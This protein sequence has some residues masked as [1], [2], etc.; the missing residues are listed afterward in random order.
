MKMENIEE[1]QVRKLIKNWIEKMRS[2][3]KQFLEMP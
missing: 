3:N 2:G 1:I